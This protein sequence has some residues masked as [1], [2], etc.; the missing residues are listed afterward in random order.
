MPIAR[1]DPSRAQARGGDGCA[2]GERAT[3]PVVSSV[4]H[5]LRSTAQ[6][7]VGRVQGGIPERSKGSDCKSDGSAFAG[8][9]PA[10]PTIPSATPRRR[11]AALAGAGTARGPLTWDCVLRW[12]HPPGGG[13][14]CGSCR[15][16][17]PRPLFAPEGA[18]THVAARAPGGGEAP[19]GGYSSMVERQPSKLHTG[20]RFPLPAPPPPGRERGHVLANRTKLHLR[21]VAAP[22]GRAAPRVPGAPRAPGDGSPAAVAQW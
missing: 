6:A 8:S 13:R 9:N 20:V 5:V 17:E 16:L 11:E 12:I 19:I 15:A 21:V 18:V 10:S 4:V 1:A 7:A 3:G 2:G 22:G 14:R